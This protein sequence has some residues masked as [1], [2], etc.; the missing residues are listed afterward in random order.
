MEE[1][2][3]KKAPNELKIKPFLEKPKK[4]PNELEIK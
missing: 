1:K 4:A 3:K 2:K